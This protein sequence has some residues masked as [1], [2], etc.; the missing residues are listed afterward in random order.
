MS[1]NIRAVKVTWGQ[2]ASLFIDPE[3]FEELVQA[4]MGEEFQYDY[5]WNDA[6]E[7]YKLWS[8]EGSRFLDH[9]RDCE[10]EKVV[11]LLEA[12]IR[13]DATSCLENLKSE[14]PEWRTFLDQEG[15]LE[16]WVDG[17]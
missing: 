11:A 17:I 5:R 9:I 7:V 15:A 8:K 6:D 3:Q 16:L 1:K 10:T 2:F 14:E 12:S 4:L 13:E